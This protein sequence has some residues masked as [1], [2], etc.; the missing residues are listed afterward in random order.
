MECARCIRNR[1]D[2]C[3]IFPKLIIRPDTNWGTICRYGR[4][5]RHDDQIGQETIEKYPHSRGQGAVKI[6]Q[7]NQGHGKSLGYSVNQF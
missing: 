7:A 5:A 2:E 6:G 1:G 4:K 3:D